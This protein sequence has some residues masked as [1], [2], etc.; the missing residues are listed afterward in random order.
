MHEM[1]SEFRRGRAIRCKA[2]RPASTDGSPV[3]D[4]HTRRTS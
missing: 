1:R 4:S 2:D 3:S